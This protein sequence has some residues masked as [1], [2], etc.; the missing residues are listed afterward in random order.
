MIAS[1][2]TEICCFFVDVFSWLPLTIRRDKRLSRAHGH[3]CRRWTVIR[4]SVSTLYDLICPVGTST[5]SGESALKLCDIWRWRLSVSQMLH[6][7][8][9][10]KMRVSECCAE[11]TQHTHVHVFHKHR[12]GQDLK[13]P[14][15]WNNQM[16][17]TG[18]T[19]VIRDNLAG[20]FQWSHLVQLGQLFQWL[21]NYI[22][23]AN[24]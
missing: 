24:G 6:H 21:R 23:L 7:D 3:S 20:Y 1:A 22:R 5:Q 14:N 8:Q 4:A 16:S 18:N 15:S 12:L 19:P 2:L 9:R 10:A 17:V 11:V 13:L